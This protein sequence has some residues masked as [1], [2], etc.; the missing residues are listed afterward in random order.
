[1]PRAGAWTKLRRFPFFLDLVMRIAFSSQNFRTITGHAGKSRRFIVYDLAPDGSA[2]ESARLDLP[3]GMALHDHHAP[4]HPLFRQGLDVVVTASAGPGF[5]QRLARH[6]IRVL[7]TGATDFATVLSALAI[8]QPVP[9]PL[10]HHHEDHAGHA[11]EHDGARDAGVQ[12][13]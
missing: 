11:G 7:V 4:D 1:M 13:P 6:G 5:V 8:G 3:S 9:P 12:Q 10:P 2:Q